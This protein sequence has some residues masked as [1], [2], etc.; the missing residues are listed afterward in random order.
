MRVIHILSRFTPLLFAI[1]DV[2]SVRVEYLSDRLRDLRDISFEFFRYRPDADTSLFLDG[3]NV[4]IA[5]D[6]SRSSSFLA[7]ISRALRH[8]RFS[9]GQFRTC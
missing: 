3:V 9:G 1:L 6:D 2:V 5:R 8:D 7:F 4:E